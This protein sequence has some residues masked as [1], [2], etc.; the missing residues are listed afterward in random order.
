DMVFSGNAGAR[1]IE[2]LLEDEFGSDNIDSD[3]ID[4]VEEYAGRLNAVLFYNGN[5]D[6]YIES[7]SPASAEYLQMYIYGEENA[8]LPGY[9]YGIYGRESVVNGKLAIAEGGLERVVDGFDLGFGARIVAGEEYLEKVHAELDKAKAL[10]TFVKTGAGKK[11]WRDNAVSVIDSEKVMGEDD[12]IIIKSSSV[13]EAM[14]VSGEGYIDGYDETG[15]KNLIVYSQNPVTRD[16]LSYSMNG[17]IDDVNMIAAIFSSLGKAYQKGINDYSTIDAFIENADKAYSHLGC[18][19]PVDGKYGFESE[20]DSYVSATDSAHI[21]AMAEIDDIYSGLLSMER[22]IVS[23]KSSVITDNEI[24]EQL[25]D[26]DEAALLAGAEAARSV[27]QQ[28]ESAYQNAKKDIDEARENYRLANE[29]YTGA[30]ESI[31]ETYSLY[32]DAE[33]EFERR[34]GIYEYASTP[35]LKES[36]SLDSGLGSATTVDGTGNTNYAELPVPDAREN[37]ERILARYKEAETLYMARKKAVDE[38]ESVALLNINTS[39]AKEYTDYKSD[40]V[41]KSESYIRICQTDAVL[42]ENIRALSFEYEQKE[43]EYYAARDTIQF[44]ADLPPDVKDDPER[45]AELEILRDRILSHINNTGD[46][47]IYSDA[48]AWYSCWIDRQ[49]SDFLNEDYRYIAAINTYADKFESLAGYVRKDIKDL[50]SGFGD[51]LSLTG[52]LENYKRY[53]YT[54][55]MKEYYKHKKESTNKYRHP[56][57]WYNARNDENSWKKRRDQNWA[58]YQ[59]YSKR[60][61]ATLNDFVKAKTEYVPVYIKYI[62]A[63]SLQKLDDVKR[64][65]GSENGYNLTD[66]DLKYLYDNT[67]SMVEIEGINTDGAR[68]EIKR[69][70]I[71]GADVK[72]KYYEVEEVVEG[73]R[74]TRGKVVVLNKDWSESE[75]TYNVTDAWIKVKQG[76]EEPAAFTVGTVYDLYDNNYDITVVSGLLRVATSNY[77]AGYM[78]GMMS[79]VQDSAQA[80][81]H[82]YTVMLRDLEDTYNSLRETAVDFNSR[83]EIR[84][85][86]FEGYKTI[87]KEF[88]WNEDGNAVQQMIISEYARQN[89][90][91]QEQQWQHQKNK[92]EERRTRWEEVTGYILNRGLRD[93]RLKGNEYIQKWRKWRIEAARQIEAGKEWWTDRDL[94]MKQEMKRWGDDSAKAANAEAA[95]KIYE[96]LQTTVDT[97]ERQIR[98]SMPGMEGITVDTDSILNKTMKNIPVDSLGVLNNTMFNMDRVAGMAGIFAFGNNASPAD[99]NK[100]WQQEYEQAFGVM[101]NLRVLDVLNGIIDNFNS[102][103]AMANLGVYRSVECDLRYSDTFGQADFVR[104]EKE[105]LWT[106]RVCVESNLIGKDK[107]KTRKFSDYVSMPNSTVMLKPIKGL[108]GEIDF[109][110]PETFANIDASELEVYVGLESSKLENEIENVF[111]SGGLFSE[112]TNGEFERLNREFAKY[113]GQWAAGELL[114]DSGFYAK[115]IF[116]GGPNMMNAGVMAAGIAGGPWAGF[117]AQMLTTGIQM[118]DGTMQWEQ[119]ALSVGTGAFTAGIGVGADYLGGAIGGGFMGA[120]VENTTK[121]LGNTLVSGVTYDPQNGFGWDSKRMKSGKTWLAAGVTAAAGSIAGGIKMDGLSSALVNGVGSSIS[122]GITT[123]DWKGSFANGMRGAVSGYVGGLIAG[124]FMEGAGSDNAYTKELVNNYATYG[125][126]LMLGSKERFDMNQIGQVDTINLVVQDLYAEYQKKKAAEQRKSVDVQEPSEM[127]K[128]TSPAEKIPDDPFELLD[129]ALVGIFTSMGRGLGQTM[130]DIGGAIKSGASAVWEGMKDFGESFVNIF[131][132]GSFS[133]DETLIQQ[134]EQRRYDEEQR[135]IQEEKIKKEREKLTKDLA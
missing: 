101:R 131:T 97:Y 22:A 3:I 63:I 104:R 126:G 73:Q 19:A 43:E 75:E 71:D 79:Y 115:P 20:L 129:N 30:M 116:P 36:S 26:K 68:E 54:R 119:A 89:R 87:M 135:K 59:G 45:I 53:A 42:N 29:R 16:N 120:V 39:A 106:I 88:A 95:Q 55:Y 51:G 72:V 78:K 123:G 27:H 33:F 84:Q 58:S 47:A 125:I 112:Y 10:D 91:F 64:Y 9:E 8:I 122:Q 92:Y 1:D 24:I 77:R 60:L 38:Q 133:T 110:K 134:E 107:Y 15:T 17:I 117:A 90:L 109:T 66:E 118:A 132:D 130:A 4:M 12:L 14:P 121:T 11:S 50:Y 105:N 13:I 128:K 2:S 52:I 18:Y 65:L 44:F 74:V 94:E 56:I 7:L 62:N 96:D 61:T 31:S 113:Y 114:K 93:W 5:T 40:F 103:L 83:S 57:R 35:Y 98:N 67:T 41:R 111:E 81:T 46:A 23:D 6:A 102:Q 70:D 28:M 49:R 34:S 76:G 86:S 100:E 37:Y 85:R 80:G 25:G 82:D 124:G 108:S 69:R 32:K 127:G 48:I 21:V 99:R